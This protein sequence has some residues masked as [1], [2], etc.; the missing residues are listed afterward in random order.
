MVE[1]NKIFVG[2]L[3]YNATDDDLYEAFQKYGKVT[4]GLFNNSIFSFTFMNW[5][6]LPQSC[7]KFYTS[8]YMFICLNFT[9]R[10]SLITT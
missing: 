1:E 3:D 7:L 4:E 8:L 9:W 2:K 5:E 6:I 10:S